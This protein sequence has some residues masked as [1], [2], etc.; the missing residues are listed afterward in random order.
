MRLL[1]FLTLLGSLSNGVVVAQPNYVPDPQL[2]T[3]LN[4]E[5][6]GLVGAD[7]Y[8]TQPGAQL[9][10]TITVNWGTWDLTGLEFLQVDSLAII[11][12]SQYPTGIFNAFPQGTTYARLDYRG[13]APLPAFPTTLRTLTVALQ[14]VGNSALQP[15]PAGLEKLNLQGPLLTE[16]PSLPADLQELLVSEAPLVT[17]VLD[18][19]LGLRYLVVGGSGVLEVLV[20]PNLE[21]LSLGDLPMTQFPILPEGLDSLSVRMLSSISTVP[22]LPEGLSYLTW[23]LMPLSGTCQFPSTL[24]RLE[25][26]DNPD[27]VHIS[28]LPEGLEFFSQT[29]NTSLRCLPYLPASLTYFFSDLLYVPNQPPNLDP[30]SVGNF[31]ISP[32]PEYPYITGHLFN[33][34]NLNGT[35]Q[36]GE[37]DMANAVIRVMPGDHMTATDRFGNYFLT[38]DPGTYTVSV[39]PVLPGWMSIPVSHTVTLSAGVA[40]EADF[41]LDCSENCLD[42]FVR[43]ECSAPSR[44]GFVH[45]LSVDHE[46]PPLDTPTQLTLLLAPEHFLVSSE[47]YPDDVDGQLLTWNVNGPGTVRVVVHTEFATPLGTETVDLAHLAILPGDWRPANNT[48]ELHLT[49]VGSYDPNDKQVIPTVLTPMEVAADTTVEYLI[50]FQNTGTYPADRVVITDTLPSDLRWNTFRSIQASH[51]HTWFVRNGVLHVAFND[52]QL[53]DSTSDEVGSHGF[54]RFSIRPSTLLQQGATVLNEANIYFDFNEPVI[55]APC[56]LSIELS[57]DVEQLDIEQVLLYPVP[58]HDLL[59]VK[60]PGSALYAMDIL[61]LD[62]RVVLH[63]GV[64]RSTTTLALEGFAPGAYV[65]RMR[66]P[67]AV[68][69]HI[70]FVKK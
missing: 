44:P 46:V 62:G 50:R 40:V 7:G 32:C 42:H 4:N 57:T 68:D 23:E 2:R 18:L 63:G 25:L 28:E 9:N 59:N 69:Q 35:Q 38:L 14:N 34:Q 43:M 61:A 24:R 49:V 70:R 1:Y 65:L 45:W 60:L 47:P 53:P 52:I 8:I 33:D 29:N 13:T 22:I 56:A 51:P 37:Y 10:L 36:F 3:I 64:H 54:V 58:A 6:P 48:A 17:S 66:S 12:S 67:F 31:L 39:D 21:L 20:P 55:T 5:I 15:L 30:L 11:W 26:Y 19:P 16:V 41:A 27:L